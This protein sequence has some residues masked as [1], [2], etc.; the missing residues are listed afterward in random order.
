M[1]EEE[2][3]R[4]GGEDNLDKPLKTLIQIE[5]HMKG[6]MFHGFYT[7]VVSMFRERKKKDLTENCWLSY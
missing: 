2:E 3:E 6:N 7:G 4:G 1:E 5:T